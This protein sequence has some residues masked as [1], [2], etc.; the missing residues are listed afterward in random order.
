MISFTTIDE[1]KTY[2][3]GDINSTSYSPIRFI[4]VETMD[5]WVHLKAFLTTIVPTSINLSDFC[6]TDDTTPN[7]I[8]LKNA[9]K[10][11]E[12]NA[13]V[14][15]LSEH[16]RVNQPSAM[17]VYKDILNIDFQNN[18][19]NFLK[20]YVPIYRMKSI[21]QSINLDIRNKDSIIFL[22]TDSDCD[23]SLTIVQDTLRAK[24]YGN[25]ITGYKKYLSYWEQN[26]DKPIIL[27]TQNAIYYEDIIFADD[28]QV[29][30]TA[31][32]LL[33]FHYSLPEMIKNE[34]G[35]EENW[36][37]LI[38]KYNKQ[39]NFNSMMSNAFLISKFDVKLFE[40]WNQKDQFDKWLIWLWAKFE[41]KSGYLNLV[42]ESCKSVDEFE[43]N[44]YFGI[45]S[46]EDEN[47]FNHYA[48]RRNLLSIMELL[49]SGKYWE[50]IHSFD[51]IR[52]LK[53]L[54]NLTEKEKIEIYITLQELEI[55][56]KALDILHI[57][58]PDLFVYLMKD[59]FKNERFS[60]YFI[61]YKIQKV[62]NKISNEFIM[63]VN[64]IATEQC[65]ELW[66]LSSRN[67]E[68]NLQYTENT[69]VFFVDALG[70]EYIGL[71]SYLLDQKGF[72]IDYN[73]G[74]C[75]IPSITEEN[76][77]FLNDKNNVKYYELDKLKHSN[78]DY[79]LS[80]IKEF[81]EVYKIINK[82]IEI[83]SRS[84]RVII[85]SDHGA[86]RLAVLAK[87]QTYKAK[88]ETKTYKYGRYCIDSL[89]DYS[90]CEG[91]INKDNYWIFA[92]YSR[93]SSQGSAFLEIH[94]GAS[95]EE[96]I[97]PIICVEK[98]SGTDK[99]ILDEKLIIKIITPEVKL[100]VN[101]KIKIG[102][103]LNKKIE[104]VI[105]IVNNKR[106]K[107]EFIDNAYW[108]E[109]DV[110][111]SENYTAKISCKETIGEIQYRVVKGISSDFDI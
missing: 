65:E 62:K 53:Y 90:S 104:E 17:R 5:M 84:K 31:Y 37:M 9:L 43:N 68:V 3:N 97:V 34:Y 106:Y 35:S 92:N 29:I 89:N 22:D 45:I 24:L 80:I 66:K 81:E 105:A 75:N 27:H 7:I 61:Q 21:L 41:I 71:I 55:D 26:P 83:L 86:S 42:L 25:E 59:D 82:T 69:T 38:N 13:I 39:K 91:C 15:P 96:C 56:E 46:D 98:K 44:L 76:K 52:R 78:I 64:S 19:D 74:W 1:L 70:V 93:F 4:N 111:R 6:E 28:V 102:F 51:A 60:N 12:K 54:T 10:K 63:N 36:Q 57:V 109:P 72:K 30:V 20:I 40:Q 58:Y 77:D 94:G 79:P 108:F 11:I 47:Y 88:D 16:L 67:S 8:R 18:S 101:K 87:G 49:P 32:Q 110:G 73:I 100:S 33:K 2:I 48:E 50:K 95:W 85:A 107:C 23:Y 103:E 99:N 14:T